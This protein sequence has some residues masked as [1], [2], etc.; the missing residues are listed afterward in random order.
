VVSQYSLIRTLAHRMFA[1]TGRLPVAIGSSTAVGSL[2]T[3]IDARDLAYGSF[4]VNLLDGVYLY[5]HRTR[6]TSTAGDGTTLTTDKAWGLNE[7]ANSTI[8]IVE[9]TGSGQS[10]AIVSNTAGP[11]SVITVAAFSPA[12]GADSEYEVY[13]D[14]ADLIRT[15][16]VDAGGLA[17]GT[18][19]FSPAVSAVIEGQSDYSLMLLHPKLLTEAIY[20]ALGQIRYLAIGPL[21]LLA[22]ADMEASG[23]LSWVQGATATPA[24]VAAAAR[25]YGG[26]Q[27]LHVL[28]SGANGY[29]ENA[30]N[31]PVDEGE[32]MFLSALVHNTGGGQAKLVPWD[33]DNAVE[34]T[35]TPIYAGKRYEELLSEFS[36]PAE[37]EE[38]QVRLQG[39]GNGD[40]G[41]WDDVILLGSDRKHHPLPSWV[42]YPEDV[43]HVGSWPSG[44]GGP[45]AD[46][47]HLDESTWREWPNWKVERR[48]PRAAHPFSLYLDPAPHE[49]IYV[50]AWVRY[51]A[52]TGDADTTVADE[53]AVLAGARVYLRKQ[54]AE[55]AVLN[56]DPTVLAGLLATKAED[57]DAWTKATTRTGS[58]PVTRMRGLRKFRMR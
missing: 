32:R 23:V 53:T 33:V 52:L 10:Q 45:L 31:V 19:T 29:V 47:F 8:K 22:D 54:L 58:A 26:L 12:V 42:V 6:G 37:C 14:N 30:V 49:R 36:V 21:S 34:I 18:L 35:P 39:V 38:L 55:G 25:V 17:G 9:G 41:Y 28:T 3:L 5:W 20:W 15:A 13:P 40:N 27:A 16:R 2:L 43:V 11:N 50:V 24:K 57:E 51:P 1:G 46:T 7:L 4:D 44:S 56:P 48:D